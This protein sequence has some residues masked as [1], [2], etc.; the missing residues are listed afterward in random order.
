MPDSFSQ[1]REMRLSSLPA[2]EALR[3]VLEPGQTIVI[4]QGYG[5][6][7]SLVAALASH[8]D[9]L[10]GSRLVLG[11]VL[12]DFPHLP[13]VRI[14]TFFPSGPFGTQRGLAE[15]NAGY[16]PLSLYEFSAAFRDGKIKPDLAFALAT[17]ERDGRHSLGVAVDFIHTAVEAAPRVVLEVSSSVPWT[18]P[19]ST[20]E[21]GGKMVLAASE[22]GVTVSQP[23]VMSLDTRIAK[24]LL[25][26]IPDC[27][28]V[29]FGI[30][31]LLEPVVVSLAGR[32]RG[33]KLHSG[34]LGPWVLP[35]I[36]RGTLDLSERRIVAAAGGTA[37]FYAML[38]QSK[39]FGVAP[40]WQTHDP[41]RL[42][43]LPNFRAVNSVLE[44]DLAGNAN[45]EYGANGRRG[46]FAGLRDFACAASS[47]DDGL[48]ILVM[49]ASHRGVSRIIPRI[50]PH[51]PTLTG[52]EV[53]VVVT[54]HGSALLRGLDAAGRAA[55]LVAV[56]DPEHRAALRAVVPCTV[57]DLKNDL[58]T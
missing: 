56:A 33:L 38:N 7:R 32:R 51:R 55:A 9:K 50:G 6:P 43:A 17:P 4:G 3:S 18:G 40:A 29:E 15:R 35:L 57:D 58:S 44:V 20:V 1:L 11:W 45:C 48:S 8:V 10:R 25:Q 47:M 31:G 21:A 46:G 14:E 12:G 41:A 39:A 52:K 30:G 27:A 49:S 36:E 28:C 19:E 54:E 23:N 42:R 2:T 16:L 34:A 22:H 24:Q 53:D 13:G 37:E 26:W 5:T